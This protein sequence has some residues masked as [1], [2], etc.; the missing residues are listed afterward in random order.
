MQVVDFHFFVFQFCQ[1]VA[2]DML[3]RVESAKTLH[4]AKTYANLARDLIKDMQYFLALASN[5]TFTAE[6]YTSGGTVLRS[7]QK[8]KLQT[9]KLTYNTSIDWHPYTPFQMSEAD[10]NDWTR[11]RRGGWWLRRGTKIEYFTKNIFFNKQ[12]KF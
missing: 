7:L 9:R 8:S 4:E 12:I 11:K 6:M 10:S 3:S 5:Q 1:G 2:E